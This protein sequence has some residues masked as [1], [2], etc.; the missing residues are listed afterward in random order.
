MHDFQMNRRQALI[1]SSLGTLSLGMPGVVMGSDDVD[2]KGGDSAIHRSYLA[3][4]SGLDFSGPSAVWRTLVSWL[5]SPEGGLALGRR[6]IVFLSLLLVA[7][8]LSGLAGRA[9]HRQQ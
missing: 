9:V 7:W 5:G 6:A 3:A 1:A 2:A 8:L 4:V